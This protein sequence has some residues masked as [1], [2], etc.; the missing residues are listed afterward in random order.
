M[1]TSPPESSVKPSS[2]RLWLRRLA[3]CEPLWV[4]AIGLLLL[5]PPRFLPAALQIDQANGRVWLV[6]LLLLGWP[7]RRMAYGTFSRRTPLDWPLLLLI[8]WLPVNLW[9]SVDPVLSW[10]A[11]GYLLLGVML[12]FALL[13]WPPTQQ[14]P[15]LI[16]WVLLIL[17]SGL[18]LAT[19]LLTELAIGKI[20]RVPAL[21]TVFQQVAAQVPGN[22][23]ANRVAGVLVVIAPLAVAL[24]VRW[25]WSKRRWAPIVCGLLALL[26]LVVLIMTQSR[27]AYLA[28]AIACA[29]ILV[30]RWPKLLFLL[31]F[32]LVLGTVIVW[33]VGVTNLLDALLAG[34]AL[35][36]LD[37]RL[38]LWSR[39]VYAISDFP[40]TGIGLGTF[41]KVIP[42]LY[43]LFSIGPDAAITHAHNLWLQVGID[44]GL[45]GLIA[46]LALFINVFVMLF[47]V[48]RHRAAAL[49]WTLAAG[50]L[51]ASVALLIHG[52]FDAP[53]W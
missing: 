52:I 30:L 9:A 42:V 37:G 49:D 24:G 32:V 27:N 26:M 2:R 48:L 7:L 35:N 17:G 10:E 16:A 43:P 3:W 28:M 41:E 21:D 29:V 20:F 23:N 51:G 8:L 12:Y 15:Q 4:A 25:D 33:R 19:P 22:V 39:A 6:L 53:L 36:G 1:T 34:G 13:N 18:A 11:L 44:L 40:F 31:P 45:P 14:R 38:E 46:Y 50:T 47:R 5:L